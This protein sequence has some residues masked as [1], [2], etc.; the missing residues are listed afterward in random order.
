MVMVM[1]VVMRRFCIIH[2]TS[3]E[4]PAKGTADRLRNSRCDS[5]SSENECNGE[6]DLN[7]VEKCVGT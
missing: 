5:G 6:F 7:H 3:L 4:S 2:F 1:G